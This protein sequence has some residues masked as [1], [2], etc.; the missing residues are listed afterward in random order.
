MANYPGSETERRFSRDKLCGVVEEIF[1][2]TGMSRDDAN[3]IANSLVAADQ[4]G[5]RSHGTLRG[6]RGIL[7]VRLLVPAFRRRYAKA[8]AHSYSGREFR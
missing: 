4:R 3:E 7:P 8:A 2:S 5:I 1:V 6:G